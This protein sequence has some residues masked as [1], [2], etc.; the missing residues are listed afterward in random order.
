MSYSSKSPGAFAK[1]S[2]R[3]EI[4]EDEMLEI[5]RDVSQMKSL[6]EKLS[7]DVTTAV[8]EDAKSALAHREA[9]LQQEEYR[10]EKLDQL[11]WVA[12]GDVAIKAVLGLALIA[13]LF[14]AVD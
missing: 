9:Q 3:I 7:A 6:V 11:R 1:N 13:A 5:T 4:L 12:V 8:D 2:V 14:L 10:L